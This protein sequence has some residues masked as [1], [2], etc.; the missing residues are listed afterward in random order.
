MK[1]YCCSYYYFPTMTSINDNC[2]CFFRKFTTSE[3]CEETVLLRTTSLI[4]RPRRFTD[5]TPRRPNSKQS[6]CGTAETQ[7]I[8]AA[9]LGHYTQSRRIHQGQDQRNCW[10]R[11]RK[12]RG[13]RIRRNKSSIASLSMSEAR[14]SAYHGEPREATPFMDRLYAVPEDRQYALQRFLGD[15]DLPL[16]PSLDDHIKGLSF[17]DGQAGEPTY[18]PSKRRRA[19]LDTNLLL[20]GAFAADFDEYSISCARTQS[21]AWLTSFQKS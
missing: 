8:S 2:T 11:K 17:V 6:S 15:E 18:P 14:D 13:P 10:L 12:L 19:S 7:S 20:I 9:C 16:T 3:P 21:M 4:V 5:P 1:A